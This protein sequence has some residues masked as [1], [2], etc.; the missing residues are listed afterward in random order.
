[1]ALEVR[2]TLVTINKENFSLVS[3]PDEKSQ[4]VQLEK[5]H[6]LGQVNLEVLL[7][8]K[9]T[10]CFAIVLFCSFLLTESE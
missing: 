2:S 1:M 9:T 5:E 10:F 3:S 4:L 8:D 7:Q 6:I